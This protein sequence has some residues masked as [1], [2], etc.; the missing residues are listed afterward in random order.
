M[1]YL[2]PQHV[3]DGGIRASA[4][5]E[6]LLPPSLLAAFA[7]RVS[8]PSLPF[9]YS[10]SL[11]PAFAYDGGRPLCATAV[12]FPVLLIGYSH[13]IFHHYFFLLVVIL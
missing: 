10:S 9:P 12:V 11:A 13:F 7:G 2:L 4:A 5:S 3:S 8:L 6:L 1:F